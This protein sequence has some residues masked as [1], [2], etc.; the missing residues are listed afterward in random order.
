MINLICWVR[1]WC[2]E[3]DGRNDDYG[4]DDDGSGNDCGDVHDGIGLVFLV[5]IVMHQSN[6]IPT[7]PF[8][9]DSGGMDALLNKTVAQVGGIIDNY[10]TPTWTYSSCNDICC[11]SSL[12]FLQ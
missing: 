5:V 1:W 11:F 10:W 7:P 3:N 12:L 8:S 2:S 9:V 6:E 4:I